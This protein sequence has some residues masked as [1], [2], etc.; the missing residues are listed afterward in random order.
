M[1]QPIPLTLPPR[2]R[3][4]EVQVQLDAAPIKHAEAIVEAYDVL[5]L[6]HDKRVFDLLRGTLGGGNA[7]LE[8]A[9]SVIGDAAMIRGA[10]NA[11]LLVKLL[12]EVE[13]KPNTEEQKPP[14]LFKLLRR[15]FNADVRRGL[16]AC[17]NVLET[18]GRNL[19]DKDA[20]KGGENAN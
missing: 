9:V 19:A 11:L 10:G 13:L 18:F 3:L 12:G 20:G 16:A 15:L 7:V 17:A 8:E 14:G 5:Q 4:R 6:M 1:A 2:N